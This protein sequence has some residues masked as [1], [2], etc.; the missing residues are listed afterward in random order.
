[1][2]WQVSFRST[3][4]LPPSNIVSSERDSV[5]IKYVVINI[6]QLLTVLELVLE[7]SPPDED[8]T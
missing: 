5:L 6:Q 7:V 8:S 1:M 3:S 2:H 4:S